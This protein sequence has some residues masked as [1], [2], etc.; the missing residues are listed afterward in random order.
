MF[1]GKQVYIR[2]LEKEDLPFRIKWLN[3]PEIR[4]TL[5]I[6]YPISLAG[7]MR[8]F[9]NSVLDDSRRNFSI[10]SR[11]NDK[12]IGMTGLLQINRI[13][14][15]AQFYM[16]IGEKDHWGRRIPDET[17][18]MILDYGFNELKLN[19]I[20]L[21]TLSN[22][23]R[24]RKVY[25]RNG[26]RLEGILRQHHFCLGKYQDLHQHSILRSEWKPE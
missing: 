6:E 17:I 5:M 15:R 4:S 18:P 3:D 1:D 16:T 23:A 8:W 21:Y 9:E 20:F 24:A 22:N 19:K 13:H 14:D 7:T 12:V 26:F 2:P 11:D 10:I 25:E